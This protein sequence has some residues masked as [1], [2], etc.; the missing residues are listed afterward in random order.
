MPTSEDGRRK[1]AEGNFNHIP[2]SVVV[3]IE[4]LANY[5]LYANLV[6]DLSYGEE[7]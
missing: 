3:Q 4:V 2:N 1:R 5:A 7:T 6:D